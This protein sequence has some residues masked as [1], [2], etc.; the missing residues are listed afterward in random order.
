[1]VKNNFFDDLE[2]RS[3]DQRNGDHLKQLTQLI[4]EAKK[5]KTNRLG[6]MTKSKI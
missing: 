5:I 3:V 6:L 2:A 4:Q 1:M